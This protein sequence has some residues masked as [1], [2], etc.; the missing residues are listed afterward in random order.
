MSIKILKD[1]EGLPTT[2]IVK[3]KGRSY[4]ATFN[5]NM[6]IEFD[7]T[8]IPSDV[9]QFFQLIFPFSLRSKFWFDRNPLNIQRGYQNT[10]GPAGTATRWEYTVP[11][12]RKAFVESIVC[13]LIRITAAAPVGRANCGITLTPAGQA[14]FYDCAVSELLDNNVGAQ[15]SVILGQS[16]ILFQGDLLTGWTA[17]TSTNGTIYYRI[18]AKI[19]EFDA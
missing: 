11:V 17:D 2:V 19:T 8:D 13:L 15:S 9:M 3:K 14:L 12:G 16:L 7:R 6:G 10:L 5:Q 1:S 4:T 18:I